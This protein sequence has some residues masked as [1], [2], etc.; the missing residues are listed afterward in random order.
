MSAACIVTGM[1]LLTPGQAAT[2]PP[3]L[4]PTGG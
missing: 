4:A 2:L 3:R 1:S